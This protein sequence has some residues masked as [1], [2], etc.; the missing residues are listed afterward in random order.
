MFVGAA[1]LANLFAS[2]GGSLTIDGFRIGLDHISAGGAGVAVGCS[3]VDT[4]LK[5]AGGAA[6]DLHGIHIT[7]AAVLA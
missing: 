7:A 5:V 2:T 6:Y 4:L 1:G 3:G